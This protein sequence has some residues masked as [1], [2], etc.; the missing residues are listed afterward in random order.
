[1]IFFGVDS[2]QRDY[3]HSH[4]INRKHAFTFQT[5]MVILQISIYLPTR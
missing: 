5:Y 4:M 3:A 2:I 1:M